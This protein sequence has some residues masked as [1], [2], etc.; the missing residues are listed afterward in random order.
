VGCLPD[1]GRRKEDQGKSRDSVD[2]VKAR[3][4]SLVGPKT[5]VRFMNIV[6]YY[7]CFHCTLSTSNSCQRRRVS[8]WSLSVQALLDSTLTCTIFAD[9]L[10]EGHNHSA[11]MY[12]VLGASTLNMILSHPDDIN[13][14]GWS[15]EEMSKEIRHQFEGWDPWFICPP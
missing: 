3:S 8:L 15:S 13:T 12:M 14:S 2:N 7:F 11:M 6:L 10:R 1:D 5:S 9:L 4:P